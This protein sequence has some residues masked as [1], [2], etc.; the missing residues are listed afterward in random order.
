MNQQNNKWRVDVRRD[1]RKQE[2]REEKCG[3]PE[4]VDRK[5]KSTGS[6][7][8]GFPCFN[9][10]DRLWKLF[11]FRHANMLPDLHGLRV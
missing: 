11:I 7:G 5:G 10:A 6:T 8:T 9:Q 3:E 2:K 4:Q 1:V